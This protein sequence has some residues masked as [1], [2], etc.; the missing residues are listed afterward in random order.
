MK[1][2]TFAIIGGLTLILLGAVFVFEPHTAKN[3]PTPI[4]TLRVATSTIEEHTDAYDIDAQYPQ[5]GA[6]GIDAQIAADMGGAVDELKAAPT[7]EHGMSV[8]KNSFTG[9]FEDVYIGSDYVSVSL[10]LSQYTGGAHPMT[11][12]SGRAYDRTTG[13]RLELADVLALT[14]ETVAD[15]SASSTAVFAK[16]FS[17]AFFAEGADTNPE[18]YSSFVVSKDAVTFIFQQYQVAPYAYGPQR[19]TV[20]RVK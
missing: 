1:R 6:P 14:G 3:V 10:I 16:Q 2:S 9:R 8:A 7:V 17:D 11:I 19:F 15:I 13:K 4:A 20:S 18:N 5:F 12:V